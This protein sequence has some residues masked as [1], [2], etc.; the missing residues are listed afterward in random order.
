M[1]SIINNIKS[2]DMKDLIMLM[3]VAATELNIKVNEPMGEP[4]AEQKAA[5]PKAKKGRVAK[6]K[7]I[8]PVIVE[9]AVEVVEQAIKEVVE[10]VEVVN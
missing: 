8:A 1:E 10:A 2:F 3:K 6:S 7:V 9:Q 5:E 4:M